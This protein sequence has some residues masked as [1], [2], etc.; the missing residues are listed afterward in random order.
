MK[1]KI[2]RSILE[3]RMFWAEKFCMKALG[4]LA[5]SS[6]CCWSWVGNGKNGTRWGSRGGQGP[7]YIGTNRCSHTKNSGLHIKCKGKPFN[8]R[9]T[10]SDLRVKRRCG[11]D[12]KS[13]LKGNNQDPNR[14]QQVRHSPQMQNLRAAKTLSDPDK[15][16]FKAIIF[17]NLQTMAYSPAPCFCK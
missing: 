6:Q 15:S 7:A 16:Y 3:K 4:H 2:F 13:K 5:C 17:K 8:D 11:C 9:V 1:R 14:E 10:W 12:V